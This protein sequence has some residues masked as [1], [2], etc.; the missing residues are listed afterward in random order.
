MRSRAL[1][2]EHEVVD[3]VVLADFA[4]AIAKPPGSD[5]GEEREPEDSKRLKPTPAELSLCS[6]HVLD[7]IPHH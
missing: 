5:R 1:A 3:D 6:S 4:V 7:G 2:G